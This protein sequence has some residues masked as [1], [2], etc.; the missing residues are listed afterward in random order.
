M[1]GK[2]K[3]S[4]ELREAEHVKKMD[5]RKITKECSEWLKGVTDREKKIRQAERENMRENG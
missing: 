2:N 5:S 3:N 1:G 4:Q